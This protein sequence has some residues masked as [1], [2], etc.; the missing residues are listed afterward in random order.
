M[1][2]SLGTPCPSGSPSK[3]RVTEMQVLTSFTPSL[4]APG[5]G[6]GAGSPPSELRPPW[7]VHPCL[8]EKES[9]QNPTSFSSDLP[10]PQLPPSTSAAPLPPAPSESNFSG[11]SDVVEQKRGSRARERTGSPLLPMRG[12]STSA[13]HHHRSPLGRLWEPQPGGLRCRDNLA[14]GL[15]TPRSVAMVTWFFL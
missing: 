2:V 5:M 6:Q 8:A 13:A 14:G 11:P 10:P 12:Q 3:P 15:V 7:T 4:P 9:P 1:G